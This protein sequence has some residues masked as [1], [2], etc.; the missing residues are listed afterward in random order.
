ML[1]A[2]GLFPRELD[3]RLK[4]PLQARILVRTSFALLIADDV[5][6]LIELGTISSADDC[7]EAHRFAVHGW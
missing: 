4:V 7:D 3:P 6:R 2:Q 1:T 5:Q